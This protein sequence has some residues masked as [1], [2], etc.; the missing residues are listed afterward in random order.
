MTYGW[1]LPTI[2]CLRSS[3]PSRVI[4][5]VIRSSFEEASHICEGRGRRRRVANALINFADR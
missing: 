5:D 2:M 1:S 4:P 3:S